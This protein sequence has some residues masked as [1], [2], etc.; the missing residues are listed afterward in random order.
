MDVQSN[1]C[2]NCYAI[3]TEENLCYSDFFF[4]IISSSFT[5]VQGLHNWIKNWTL[6]ARP[7]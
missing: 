3:E 1:L 7:I 5:D 4:S 6:S 2:H